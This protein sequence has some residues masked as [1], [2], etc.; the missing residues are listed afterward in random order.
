M[1]LAAAD[2]IR[3]HPVRTQKIKEIELFPYQNLVKN[4]ITLVPTD[5]FGHEQLDRVFTA[6]YRLNQ[7]EVT[8]FISHRENAAEAEKLAEAY[9]DFL[10]AYGGTSLPG[11]TGIKHARIVHIFDTY[12]LVFSH[13]RF[14]AGIHEAGDRKAAEKMAGIF[15]QRLK[16]ASNE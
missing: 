2:F 3:Q 12:E 14:L 13:G 15:L 11:Q 8:L 10:V 4:S 6:T 16:E 5:A 7:T 1:T 9:H